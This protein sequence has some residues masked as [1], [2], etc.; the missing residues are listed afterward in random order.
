MNTFFKPFEKFHGFSFLLGIAFGC[1]LALTLFSYLVPTG[2]AM[3]R[4]N[5][6]KI[7]DNQEKKNKS[8]MNT[9]YQKEQ[10]DTAST[11]TE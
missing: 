8:E 5:H 1:A 9:L 11:S 7:S 4:L 2:P 3:I 10:V 6:A